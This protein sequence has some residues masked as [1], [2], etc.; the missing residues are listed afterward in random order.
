MRGLVSIGRGGV[1]TGLLRRG[2]V[3]RV[4]EGEGVEEDE[5]KGKVWIGRGGGEGKVGKG[6]KGLGKRKGGGEGK[7]G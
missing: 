3:G 6:R 2:G 1:G 4:R 7:D 5:K